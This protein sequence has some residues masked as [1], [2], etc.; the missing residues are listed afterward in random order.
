MRNLGPDDYLM[1][2]AWIVY[3]A[4]LVLCTV[5]V[6]NG[7]GRHLYYLKPD[8]IVT[9]MKYNLI[10]QPFGVMASALGKV[11]VAFL[12]LRLIG[13]TTVWRR[14]FLYSNAMLF[15]LLSILSFVLFFAQCTPL[16]ATW[17]PVPGARCWNPTVTTTYGI[18]QSAYGTV[19]DFIL[20]FMPITF[21]W[22]LKLSVKKKLGLCILLGLGVIAGVC[23]AFRTQQAAKLAYHVD[24]IWETFALFVW[25]SAEASIVIICGCVPTA[26]PLSYELRTKY[27][28]PGSAR[29]TLLDQSGNSTNVSS[30]TENAQCASKNNQPHVGSKGINVEQSFVVDLHDRISESVPRSTEEHIIV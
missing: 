2:V 24:H 9:V 7:G 22:R 17:E 18:F 25:G 3:L 20:A 6:V 28:Q 19:L 23:A 13:P 12:V 11:S 8:E 10:C 27:S 15:M 4:G 21:I 16:R 1:F 14:R 26:K 5:Y 30:T 29:T